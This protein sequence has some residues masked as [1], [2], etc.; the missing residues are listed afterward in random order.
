MERTLR[1]GHTFSDSGVRYGTGRSMFRPCRRTPTFR[2]HCTIPGILD[3]G[4]QH[5]I[6]LLQNELLDVY[7]FRKSMTYVMR[8]LPNISIITRDYI[9]Q[10]YAQIN[11]SFTKSITPM[12]LDEFSNC[13]SLNG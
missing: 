2:F 13:K 6:K 11:Q 5:T 12:Y 7:L 4:I 8:N 9:N 3:K 10:F 1:V